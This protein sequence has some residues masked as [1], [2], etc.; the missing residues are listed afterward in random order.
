MPSLEFDHAGIATREPDRLAAL[1]ADL[2][3]ATVVHEEEIEGMGITF[4]DAG[5]AYLE[6]LEP[7][8][9]D[10]IDR[11]LDDGGPGIHHL[12]FRTDDLP[13]AVERARTLDADPIDDEPRP[14]AWGSAVAF[15]HPASTG[16]VLIELVDR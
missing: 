4:L 3:G 13:A 9:D 6:L 7:G 1:Y 14:G 16:G 5:S 11:Y 2:L 10:P 8:E 12:A 15:L